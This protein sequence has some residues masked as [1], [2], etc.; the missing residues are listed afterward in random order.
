MAGDAGRAVQ[1]VIIVDVAVGA[2]AR[3]NGVQPGEREPG[4]VVIEGGT[5]PGAGAVALVAGLR[6]VRCHVIGIGGSLEILQVAAHA[7]AAG[8]IVVVVDV[9]VGAGTWRH[10]VQAG[11]DKAGGGMIKFCVGPLHG[12]VTLLASRREACVGHR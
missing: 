6:E 11:Q 12:I 7:G 2:G 1:A 9:A 5:E 4:A 3:G 10:G 8:Q